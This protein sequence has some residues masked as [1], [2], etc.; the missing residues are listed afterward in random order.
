MLSIKPGVVCDHVSYDLTRIW[1]DSEQ[2]ADYATDVTDRYTSAE[3]AQMVGDLVTKGMQEQLEKLEQEALAQLE[4][5]EAYPPQ[6]K[7]GPPWIIT[8]AKGFS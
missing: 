8:S 7:S 5:Q 4:K 1:V 2:E 6:S 3:F